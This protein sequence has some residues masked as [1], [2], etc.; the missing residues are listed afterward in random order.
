[1]NFTKYKLLFVWLLVAPVLIYGSDDIVKS[2]GFPKFPV[3]TNTVIAGAPV[4]QQPKHINGTEQEIR[5]EKHGLAYPAFYDWNGDGKTDLLVGEFETGA[6]NIKV[7]LNTGTAKKPKYSGKYFYATDVHGDTISAYQW[8]CIG[9]HPRFVDLNN[10]G[11]TDLLTGQYN[12]GL[13]SVWYG[14]EKGFLPHQFVDQLGYSPDMR[15]VLFNHNDQDPLNNLYWNYTS[16]AFADFNGDGLNDLFVGGSGSELRVALNTG[17]NENPKFGL[18]KHLLDVYGLP[19]SVVAPTEKEKKEA[20][21]AYRLPLYSGVEKSFVTPVDW[22]NDGVLDL[23]VTHAYTSNK[24]KDPIVFFR[25]INTDKGLRFASAVSL[26]TAADAKKTFPGCQPN[27]TITDYNHDG[28]KDIVFGIS[29]PT[30]NGFEIDS[31]IS[32][33][34]IHDIG[35]ETPG[36]D[37]GRALVYEG[38]LEGIKKKIESDIN[39]KNYFLGKLNDY[40]Y[41][42]LRHR[43]YVYVMLGK[44][45]PSKAIALTGVKAKDEVI[46]ENKIQKSSNSD[47]PVSYT[48]KSQGAVSYGQSS[49]VEVTLKIMDGWYGYTDNEANRSL[50]MIPTTV[51]FEFPDGFVTEGELITPEPTQKGTYQ[52]YKG[53]ALRFAQKFKNTGLKSNGKFLQIGSYPVKVT[54]RYQTCNDELCLPP[55]T[56]TVEIMINI[57]TN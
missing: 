5:T 57:T 37:A 27:I 49:E 32:N 3:I 8:C 23:L 29:L 10:D 55:V 46:V 6:S 9:T 45:N 16:A 19:L 36:K 40:K 35:I 43:G 30:V 47:G 1:M 17:T 41:L 21:N 54:I 50:G 22:D 53:S 12:P 18:R 15:L 24:T 51:R 31:L 33:S 26:F 11:F 39:Y 13:I 48:V 56:E 42:T 28:I 4:L 20:E 34:Y 7:Y 2:T 25:G 14:S 44:K 52:I 38:G